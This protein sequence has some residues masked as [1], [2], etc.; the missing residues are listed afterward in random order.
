MID[1]PTLLIQ[2]PIVGIFIWY[3][4]RIS[5]QFS[6]TLQKRDEMYEKRNDAL[7]RAIESSTTATVKLCE[8]MTSHDAWTR[9]ALEQR[10]ANA[11]SRKG[12]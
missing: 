8:S 7:V 2:I 6:E 5:R 9:E 4:E 10:Q 1:W 11:R 3:S 12:D